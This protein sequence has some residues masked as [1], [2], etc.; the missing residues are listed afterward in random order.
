MIAKAGIRPR[1]T[2]FKKVKNLIGCSSPI[3]YVKDMFLPNKE[4]SPEGT[5]VAAV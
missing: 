5:K 3:C 4:K 1:D 2:A